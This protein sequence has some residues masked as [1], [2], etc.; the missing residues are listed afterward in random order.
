[1]GGL[2]FADTVAD[3]GQP[4]IVPRLSLELYKQL[5]ARYQR[6]LETIF[7]KVVIPREAPGKVDHGDIDYLV[8]GLRSP[9]TE[10]NV[11]DLIRD[12]FKAE[13]HILRGGSASYAVPD[14]ATIGLYVQV[15]VELCVGHGTSNS[16]ELFEWTR[17]VKS[18]SDLLQIIGVSHRPLGLVCNDQGL[19]VRVQE[20]EP[21][22]KKKAL[23]FLT[24]SPEEALEFYGLDVAKYQAG[25][26]DEKDLFDWAC[27][28]RFFACETFQ[29]RTEKHNDR[30][31]QTKRPMYR[32]FV[33][34]YIPSHAGKGA[35]KA[36]TREEVLH[37]AIRVFGKQ[38]GYDAMMEEHHLKT[39]E[40]ELWKEIREA[41]PVQS[42]SLALILRGLRRWVAFE[43]G[44]PLIAKEP[45]LAEPLVWSKFVSPDTRDVVL[46]WV[47]DN[48]GQVKSLEKARAS[49]SKEAAKNIL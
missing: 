37:E 7:E 23:L 43:N 49:A 16:A 9:Y 22:N 3:S 48:Y 26:T 47:K 4:I 20:I 33:E 11:W 19:H 13:A 42:N 35:C 6:E 24:R 18:D 21:Y 40:E 15:D 27:S 32:R 28:G 12:L 30:A 1:M 10:S 45:N 29:S 46:A 41:V 44:R 17:F 38:A 25:F 8:D 34:E 14:P 36:C 2:A 5:S 39:A 31:R